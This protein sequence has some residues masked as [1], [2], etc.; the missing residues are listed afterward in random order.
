MIAEFLE[1]LPFCLLMI[2]GAAECLPLAIIYS[3]F[4]CIPEYARSYFI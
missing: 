4:H 1:T 3:A 2:D